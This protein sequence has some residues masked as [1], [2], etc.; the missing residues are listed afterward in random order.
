MKS[1]KIIYCVLPFCI[2]IA[3]ILFL[4]IYNAN[5][6]LKY[7]FEKFLG[8]GFSAENIDLGWCSARA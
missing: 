8:K 7:E 6:I 3:L 1:K 5:K 4:L 2:G